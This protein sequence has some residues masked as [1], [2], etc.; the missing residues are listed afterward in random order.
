MNLA[1][2]LLRDGFRKEYQAA[3]LVTNDSDL[4]EPVRMVRKELGLVVGILN[5]HRKASRVLA[6]EALANPPRRLAGVAVTR[7]AKGRPRRHYEARGVV[8]AR[9][10]RDAS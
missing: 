6:R 4:L 5:P 8:R 7:V 1:T 3:V 9:V 2:H 10:C